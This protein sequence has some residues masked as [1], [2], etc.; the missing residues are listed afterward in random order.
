MKSIVPELSRSDMLELVAEQRK[1]FRLIGSQK[2][3]PGL[4]LFEYDLTTGEL[5]HASMKKEIQL[6]M[7]GATG[8]KARVD[9]KAL[10]LYIQALN[11]E[12]AMRKV[13]K[14]LRRKEVRETILKQQKNG[15]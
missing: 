8:A 10:C 1:E 9:A 12:N 6:E 14:M 5:R 15:K 7:D 4:T 2:R 13:H 3:I 11:E